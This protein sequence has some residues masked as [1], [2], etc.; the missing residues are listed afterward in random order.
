MMGWPAFD[1]AL[2]GG[3]VETEDATP[4]QKRMDVHCVEC[5]SHLGYLYDNGHTPNKVHYCING[6][7]LV[8]DQTQTP[9][10]RTPPPPPDTEETVADL[11]TPPQA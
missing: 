4:G 9:P 3:V 1:A 11:T 10:P 5:K 8:V 6:T 7:A 2:P